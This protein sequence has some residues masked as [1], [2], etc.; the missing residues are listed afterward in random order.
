MLRPQHK[1]EWRADPHI[2]TEIHIN[3]YIYIRILYIIF[4]Y[5]STLLHK[6]FN[7]NTSW[8]GCYCA[9]L[10]TSLMFRWKFSISELYIFTGNDTC[11]GF[12]FFYTDSDNIYYV[13][14]IHICILYACILHKRSHGLWSEN[15]RAASKPIH[16]HTHK[17]TQM[18]V[19][20][21]TRPG[22]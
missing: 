12:V 7:L 2:V 17:P 1:I 18:Y 5:I 9:F 22:N 19:K 8:H 6:E 13:L 20:I 14:Y 21:F 11:S 4:I 15:Q 3:I 10:L 16:T